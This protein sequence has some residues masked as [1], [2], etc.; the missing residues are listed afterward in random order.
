MNQSDVA[1][2][3]NEIRRAILDARRSQA[4]GHFCEDSHD[5]NLVLWLAD[6]AFKKIAAYIALPDEPCTDLLLDVCEEV[7]IQ[8]LVPRIAGDHLEW[9]MFNW[10]DLEE[11]EFGVLEPTGPSEP[12]QVD[13][14]IVPAL[15]A[16][17]DGTRL[18]RGKG[19]YDR[20]LASLPASVP[21][22]ALVH[23]EELFNELPSEPHDRKVNWVSTCLGL[24][25]VEQ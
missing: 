15:A 10:D 8:V 7:G 19:Y 4:V 1:Q 23:E 16:A 13:A 24:H 18:G 14:I 20:A 11:G 22:V 21:V 2:S 9:A 6:N 17:E 5:E 3:K 12:L 25:E